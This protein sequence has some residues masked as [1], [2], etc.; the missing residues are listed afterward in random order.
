MSQSK[1]NDFANRFMKNP[2]GMGVGVK[3]LGIAGLAG[4]GMTQSL[5]T[6]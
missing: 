3:L 5:Y 2:K 6:G 1:L 4:Y